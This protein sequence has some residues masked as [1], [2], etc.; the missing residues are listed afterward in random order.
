MGLYVTALN[1][2]LFLFQLQFCITFTHTVN[3]IRIG[4]DFPR[5]G[6]N[7]LAGYMVFMLVLFGN[8]YVNA[9]I[10]RRSRQTTAP[11]DK[12][13]ANGSPVANGSTHRIIRTKKAE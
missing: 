13:V 12:G 9:Y 7:L 4:C 2:T 10:R 8:F 1:G 3:S 6:Q 5:W 11:K